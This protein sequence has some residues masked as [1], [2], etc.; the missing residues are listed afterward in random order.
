MAAS[1]IGSRSTKVGVRKEKLGVAN[2]RQ[3]LRPVGAVLASRMGYEPIGKIIFVEQLAEIGRLLQLVR[4]SSMLSERA[5]HRHESSLGN[6]FWRHQGSVEQRRESVSI[7]ARK[8]GIT[9]RSGREVL[10]SPER[11]DRFSKHRGAKDPA[12]PGRRYV[13]SMPKLG[14]T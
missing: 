6:K 7:R 13:S 3:D 11:E 8:N 2:R 1:D 5:H 4:G 12:R 10:R 9:V 14:A